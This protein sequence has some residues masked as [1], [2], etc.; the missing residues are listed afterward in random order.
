MRWGSGWREQGQMWILLGLVPICLLRN[1]VAPPFSPTGPCWQ[2]KTDRI[3]MPIISGP[4][5]GIPPIA[6]GKGVQGE[7]MEKEFEKE[8]EV[9]EHKANLKTAKWKGKLV[10]WGRRR[11]RTAWTLRAMIL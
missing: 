9:G 11:A 1:H 8:R 4:D 10:R 6:Q 3:V 5:I 7:K 2:S